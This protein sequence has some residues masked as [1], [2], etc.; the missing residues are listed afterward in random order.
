MRQ[1]LHQLAVSLGLELAALMMQDEVA[2]LCGGRYERQRDRQAT[3]H[4][5]QRGVI[6]IAG[7]K[8]ALERPRVRSTLSRPAPRGKL[9]RLLPVR[10]TSSIVNCLRPDEKALRNAYY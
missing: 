5:Q 10:A 9:L 6:T 2:Q 1:G 3:R 7:Q 4:G 8:M